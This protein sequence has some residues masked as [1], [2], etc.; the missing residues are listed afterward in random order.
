MAHTHQHGP[1]THDR[2]FAFGVGLNLAFV[3]VE[4]LYGV[5][6]G[7]LALVADAGHNFGD[8]V[9][10]LLA[11]GAAVAARKPS[12]ERR[13]YGL[14]RATILAALVSALLLL[15]AMGGILWEAFG[16]IFAPAPVPGKTLIIVAGIGVVV[17][18]AT[19]LLFMA[20]RKHDLNI[21]A[22]FL[23]MGADAA[24][25]LG[26]VSA[27]VAILATGWLWLDPAISLAIVIVVLFGTWGLLR[28]SLNLAMDAVPRGIDP[29]SVRE[30]LSGLPGVNGVHDLHI[31]GMSTTETALTVHL[32]MARPG[33]P[34]RFL[35]EVCQDLRGRY[36][37]GHATIQI[38]SGTAPCELAPK[39][40]E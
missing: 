34:D 21:R 37:I 31:W 39:A 27:G 24:V 20:G 33:D 18:S 30:F 38:E 1:R 3:A 11:W 28:D 22:A 13:T 26:V 12:T 16:R 35:H 8:V 5:L 19:A 29:I 2:A 10:L 17:N 15:V 4:L 9:S 36:G 6:A 32:V 40:S 25:S 23:H 14:R 7:S